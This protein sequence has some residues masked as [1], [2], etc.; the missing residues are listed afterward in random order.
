MNRIDSP[1]LTSQ[2]R[3]IHPLLRERTRGEGDLRLRQRRQNFAQR[4]T[5]RLPGK[6]P[7]ARINF[8]VQSEKHGS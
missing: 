3:M 5:F 6:S 4:E 2:R 8:V 7:L 1:S